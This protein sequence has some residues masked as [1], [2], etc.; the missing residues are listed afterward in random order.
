MDR[1]SGKSI[2]FDAVRILCFSTPKHGARSTWRVFLSPK[3]TA[4][5]RDAWATRVRS[6]EDEGDEFMRGL[7]RMREER[8]QERELL[9]QK[10]QE[11]IERLEQRYSRSVRK[12]GSSLSGWSKRGRR[13]VRKANRSARKANRTV[14]S[15]CC[16]WRAVRAEQRDHTA[17]E[18]AGGTI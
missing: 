1:L 10:R 14:R 15:S 13:S 12:V 11:E 5:T 9:K 8:Q 7:K 6:E 16:M 3:P 18:G 4:R 2:V 17:S